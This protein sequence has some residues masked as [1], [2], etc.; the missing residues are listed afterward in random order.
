MPLAA[1][2]FAAVAYQFLSLR[3]IPVY[4]E[5]NR[6]H[7]LPTPEWPRLMISLGL[8]IPLALVG[9][10]YFFATNRT[11][12][13]LSLGFI[14]ASLIF[15]H[16]PVGF[17]ERFLE[18]LPVITALFASFG[19]LRLVRHFSR[20]VLQTMIATIVLVTLTFSHFTPF[21]NDLVAIA[22]QSPPQYMPNQFLGP[23]RHLKE[24]TA[25]TEAILSTQST[26][27]F[28]VAYAGRPVV[29]GH[30]VATAR[31]H[32]KNKIVREFFSIT[33]D[34]PSSLALFDKTKAS[35][36]FWGPEESWSSRGQ[37]DPA[38]AFYLEKKYDNGF[39]QLFKLK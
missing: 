16:L 28:L 34:N 7:V 38:H 14:G 21:R 4:E 29:I 6:Q 32:E 30:R 26:G 37:F 31:Y 35:W 39:V 33:A 5:W 24:L 19:L 20:P 3:S 27:N 25:P 2:S 18:G 11:L 17:Q 12:A 23:M 13:A 1:G 10:R 9:G 22:R 15:S 8:L 36:L